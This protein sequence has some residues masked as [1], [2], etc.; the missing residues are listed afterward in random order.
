MFRIPSILLLVTTT[1]L[2]QVGPQAEISL[3][4][5]IQHF[6][7]PTLSW[8]MFAACDRNSDDQLD[9]L[10]A[11]NALDSISIEKR[12]TFRML[13]KDRDGNLQWNEFDQ[14]FRDTIDSSNSFKITPSREFREPIDPAATAGPTTRELALIQ[15]V[16]RDRDRKLSPQ[17]F[18]R[19]L[20]QSE[21]P[22]EPQFSDIDTDGSGQI[23]EKEFRPIMQLLPDGGQTLL[24]TH[25]KSS[26]TLPPNYRQA[27]VDNSGSLTLEEFELALIAIDP[28]LRRWSERIF[29]AADSNGN[30][31]LVRQELEHATKAG[32][33][34]NK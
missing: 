6:Y 8:G 10:E 32:I 5:V 4:P 20:R 12:G 24:M 29:K 11:A 31:E 2:A 26:S 1:A 7:S 22:N 30:N 18:R 13:D 3:A 34:R 15:L 19:F 16:D 28:S 27:D 25:E 21:L 23:T 9:L 17:E 33:E 14:L